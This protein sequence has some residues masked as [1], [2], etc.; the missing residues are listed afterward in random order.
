MGGGGDSRI[1]CQTS[2]LTS[3]RKVAMPVSPFRRS[4][5]GYRWES[6]VGNRPQMFQSLS[7]V[8]ACSPW[9]SCSTAAGCR[10][11]EIR[12]LPR[13]ERRF[14]SRNRTRPYCCRCCG[15]WS[16]GSSAFTAGYLH[17]DVKPQNMVV[18][19]DTLKYIDIGGAVIPKVSSDSVMKSHPSSLY[20]PYS[21]RHKFKRIDEE[22]I[23]MVPGGRDEMFARELAFAMGKGPEKDA[24][25]KG[26]PCRRR[27]VKPRRA[28]G[29]LCWIVAALV[30]IVA[31]IAQYYDIKNRAG[32]NPRLFVNISRIDRRLFMLRHYCMHEIWTVIWGA[33]GNYT[34]PP[35]AETRVFTS[36]SGRAPGRGGGEPDMIRRIIS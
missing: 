22:L 33:H 4:D 8:A 19:G 12:V 23:G 3:R 16:L 14:W 34:G 21:Y 20:T 32:L 6:R 31:C 24:E 28:S 13:R 10:L 30:T 9:K 27:R 2:V 7:T 35:D 26:K 29:Q 15:R 5:I 1:S 17:G 36:R 11:R 18:C 25:I